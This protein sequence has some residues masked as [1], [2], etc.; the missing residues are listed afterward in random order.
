MLTYFQFRNRE[1]DLFDRKSASKEDSFHG[2]NQYKFLGQKRVFSIQKDKR[3]KFSSEEKDEENM[4]KKRLNFFKNFSDSKKNVSKSKGPFKIK[5]K[6]ED[7]KK[8]SAGPNPSSTNF[9]FLGK[10]NSLIKKQKISEKK[11]DTENSLSD[12]K[13]KY[14]FLKR[15]AFGEEFESQRVQ[16]IYSFMKKNFKKLPKSE[17]N[18]KDLMNTYRILENINKLNTKKYDRNPKKEENL[19]LNE[20][21]K[22]D[23]SD[24]FN[25]FYNDN[26]CVE[27]LE[28]ECI[29]VECGKT[30]KTSDQWKKHYETHF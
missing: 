24:F 25:N 10:E 28:Y 15:E 23:Q 21:K 1:N 17:F 13:G 19:N 6:N 26:D 20:N 7:L 12:K 9:I 11:E 14:D 29:F 22:Q 18:T 5:K 2:F 8:K 27:K 30:F 4:E 16:T 3:T